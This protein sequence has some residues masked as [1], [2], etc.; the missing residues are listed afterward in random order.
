MNSFVKSA[1]RNHSTYR[2]HFHGLHLVYCALDDTH[3][4]SLI[5]HALDH[6]IERKNCLTT[7]FFETLNTTPIKKLHALI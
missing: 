7:T 5:P 4:H 3:I 6:E 2:E 1:R